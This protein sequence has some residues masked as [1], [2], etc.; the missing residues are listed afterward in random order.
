[1]KKLVI[2]S[3]LFVGLFSN[4]QQPY[5]LVNGSFETHYGVG[6]FGSESFTKLHLGPSWYAHTGE[7]EVIHESYNGPYGATPHGDRFVR[8]SQTLYSNVRKGD[9]FF[10]YYPMEAGQTYDLSYF[11]KTAGGFDK[12]YVIATNSATV[13]FTGD[14]ASYIINNNGINSILPTNDRQIVS[15][16]SS[17]SSSAWSNQVNV[18]FTAAKKYTQLLFI[19]YMSGSG[20]GSVYID[21]V[22]MSGPLAQ[23][24]IAMALNG[25]N[26]LSGNPARVC[27]GDPLMM[28]AKGT[29]DTQFDHNGNIAY[30]LGI[31]RIDASGNGVDWHYEWNNILPSFGLI[32]LQDKYVFTSPQG[33]TTEYMVKLAINSGPNNVWL[34]Q[35]Q[36]IIVTGKPD[37][38]FGVNLINQPGHPTTRKVKGLPAGSYTYKWYEGTTTTGTVI[39]TANQIGIVKSQNGV[40]PYTVVVTDI[41][42]G[43]ST[44]KTTNVIYQN[45]V[46]LDP[47]D[48]LGFG[49]TEANNLEGKDSFVIYPNPASSVLNI[50]SKNNFDTVVIYNLQGKKVI[51]SKDRSITIS[52]LNDGV[53]FIKIYKD[54]EMISSNKFVKQ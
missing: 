18:S 50:Q 43:C 39:S 23:S 3:L 45:T 27:S 25:V 17:S 52:A 9:S 4:A 48:D 14:A 16:I 28:D 19:P 46:V 41:N 8:L 33:V 26:A 29:V 31:Y 1:M 36:K 24:S 38:N 35:S 42:T 2:T 37:F 54:G 34:E 21:N 10:M 6:G 5:E 22:T 47:K 32:D 11:Y 49:K 12:F 51:T 15:T 44:A 40:Y 13:N 30:F 7:P 53:Y 20:S